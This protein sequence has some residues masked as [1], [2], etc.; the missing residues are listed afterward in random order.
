MDMLTQQHC[1]THV[2]CPIALLQ[3]SKAGGHLQWAWLPHQR[4]DGHLQKAWLPRSK[5]DG[6]LQN[7]LLPHRKAFMGPK[8]EGALQHL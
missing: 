6:H 2:A 5:A 1:D 8:G 3:A 4:A 7:V